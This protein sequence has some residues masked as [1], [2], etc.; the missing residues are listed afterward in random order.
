MFVQ[1]LYAVEKFEQAFLYAYCVMW[2]R[3]SF[4]T[5]LLLALLV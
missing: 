1:E 4:S 3:L 5:H 2:V